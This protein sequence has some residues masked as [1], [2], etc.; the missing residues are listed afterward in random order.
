MTPARRENFE[1]LLRP[2]HI[3]FIG[4]AD[5][6]VAVGEALRRGYGGK[7][8]PVNPKR[9][10]MAG[11]PCFAS[12]EDLPETPDAAYVAVA[13]ARVPDML[14]QLAR[15]G[16]G[17]V[18]CYSAGFKE[19]GNHTLEIELIDAAGDMAVIGP[20]CYGLINYLDNVALWPFAHGGWSP[21]YGAAIVTQSGMFSSDITMAQRSLPLSYM[22]SAGNQAVLGLED[23]TDLFCN[24][25]EVRAIGLHIEGLR[26]VSRFERI[27]LKALEGGT[28]IVALKTGRS[29][30]GSALAVSHTGSLSGSAALYDALFERVGIISVDSPAQMLETLKFLCV[31]DAPKG[32]RI[33]GFTCSG[34]GAAMLADHAETIGQTFP[35]VEEAQADRLRAVLPLI[36]TVSNPLDYTTPI[37][38]LPEHS[39]PVFAEAMARNDIDAALLVQDYPAPGLDETQF[40]YRNDAMAFSDAAAARKIPA[41]ICSTIPENFDT[42]S[43]EALIARGVAPMQGLHEAMNA[44][45]DA[46]NWQAAR[47]RVAADRPAP[48]VAARA[49]DDSEALDEAAGKAWVARAGVAVP[50][51]VTTDAAGLGDAGMGIGYP[52]ALKMVGAHLLHKTEAGAV[53]LG[54]DGPEALI[55]AELT[56]R[57]AVAAHDS[58]TATGRYLVERMCP[59][60]LAELVV[61]IRLD[62]QFGYV[63]TL[64]SGG[65]LVELVADVRTV[66]LPT[67]AAQICA[68]L[69]SLKVARLMAG[70]RGRAAVDI[71][72]LAVR[73]ERFAEAVASIGNVEEVEINPLFVY[74]DD[75]VAV[76]V[77]MRVAKQ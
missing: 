63:L 45:R 52:V 72:A 70:F 3:A 18:A 59:A 21:G 6:E 5:A 71:D 60:P 25:P 50:E 54:I 56:M 61:A 8:W 68:A 48:L 67:S 27:A 22:I 9:A 40:L 4:G 12:L 77:L 55:D 75:C 51:G 37:W 28:P 47:N 76:D 36:A 17:G 38:G 43:R 10:A 39:G 20:N 44:M 14:A 13:A 49:A 34:G 69:G 19:S 53:A 64:G 57:E 7:I 31:A 62:P 2:R 58:A 23:F 35:K 30:I 16:T 41:A 46:A 74:A 66:L 65:V 42:G 15:M 1:R 11:V 24:R 29:D 73:I 32:N 33:A 26:D